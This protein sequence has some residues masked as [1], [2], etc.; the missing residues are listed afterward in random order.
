[1]REKIRR[2]N[3]NTMMMA[4]IIICVLFAYKMMCDIEKINSQF[5]QDEID[6]VECHNLLCSLSKEIED[7]EI[8]DVRLIN[9]G[10]VESKN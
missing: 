7:K 2:V 1:M 10:H 6:L 8:V 4:F 3:A 5:K 9:G